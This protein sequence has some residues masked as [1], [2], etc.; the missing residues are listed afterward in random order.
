MKLLVLTDLHL[1]FNF[2]KLFSIECDYV[3]VI[4][5]LYNI[6][7]SNSKEDEVNLDLVFKS[8][9]AITKKP[10]Y[11]VPGNHDPSFCFLEN[12]K[13]QHATNFHHK[14]IAI[15]G[16]SFLGY[17]GSTS[18]YYVESGKIAWEGYPNIEMGSILNNFRKVDVLVTHQGPS[19]FGTSD[20][21][22]KPL[23]SKSRVDGGSETVREY[24]LQYEPRV[25]LHGHTHSGRGLLYLGKSMIVNP[26]AY[27]DGYY[28]I[29][30]IK[31][32]IKVEFLQ[33]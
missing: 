8:L 10:I 21:N 13:Y 28:C 11:F 31:E 4:G 17:G 7:H 12:A 2:E 16:L 1:N 25:V 26:G 23:D 6:D 30:D 32:K 22:R 18:S 9:S 14:L 19:N 20:Y 29:V 15:D 27:R 24:I 5:D 33:V 3:I